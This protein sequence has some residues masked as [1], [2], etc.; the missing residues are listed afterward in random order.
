MSR[1]IKF[2]GKSIGIGEWIYGYLFN[3]GG[4]D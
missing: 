3:Y 1:G 4:I 2:R